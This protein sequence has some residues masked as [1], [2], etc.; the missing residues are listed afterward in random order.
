MAWT[1][2]AS[3]VS[4]LPSEGSGTVSPVAG[5]TTKHLASINGWLPIELVREGDQSEVGDLRPPLCTDTHPGCS[6]AQG[7][8][9]LA[10]CPHGTP[11]PP[12]ALAPKSCYYF[13]HPLPL[14]KLP[15]PVSFLLK[16]L[17]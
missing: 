4:V 17:N 15:C 2:V 7:W 11:T 10:Q 5:H 3:P 8:P 1:Y 12:L 9:S 16:V 6:T 13:E 14:K